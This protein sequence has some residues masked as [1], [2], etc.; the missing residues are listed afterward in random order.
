MNAV[1][2][3]PEGIKVGVVGIGLMGSSIIVSL[4]TSGH[5][6]VAIAP[7]ES[8]YANA[9]EKITA[10]FDTCAR[11]VEMGHPLPWYLSRLTISKD[12]VKLAD[13]GLVLE[14]VIEQADIKAKVYQ[15]IT[16]VVP[17][18][19]V[20]A[21]NTSAIPI[22]SLQQLVDGPERFLGI[23][24]AEPA[25][26]T[27]FMEITC[28]QHTD[29]RYAQWVYNLAYHWGKEPTLLRTDIKGFITNRLM[30]AV[31]REIFHL[32][33]SGQATMEDAD[34]VFKYDVGSWI[35]LMGLF[36]RIDYTGVEDWIAAFKT[37][38]P[39][40]SNSEAVPDI[41]KKMVDQN[42]RGTQNLKGLFSYTPEQARQWDDAFAIFNAEIF[43]LAAQYPAEADANVY[44]GQIETR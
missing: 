30:Y 5:R 4:L 34:K 14:C 1:C 12:Y 38:I 15:A 20:I 18:T 26:C 3:M 31:Y 10:L 11:S 40:L 2:T 37:L 43:K 41:M 24:Y 13:C 25:F 16:N 22:S 42:G 9:H 21:S 44:T 33:N 36:M 17:R 32:V 35:T 29:Q 6:V 8:D 7:I 23:H 39:Q 19:T 27:R 28:G